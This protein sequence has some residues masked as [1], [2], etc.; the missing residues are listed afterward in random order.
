MVQSGLALNPLTLTKFVVWIIVVIS[1]TV[2]LI[3]GR[4]TK[5]TRLAFVI[6]GVILFGFIYGAVLAPG[7]NPNPVASVR[8]L[9]KGLLV[10]KKLVAPVVGMLVVMLAITVVSNKSFCGYACQLG[11][12]QDLLHR[13]PTPKWQPPFWLSNTIRIIAFLALVGGLA[14]AGLDWIGVIDPFQL[15]QFNFTLPIILASVGV[16]A[17]SLF[18]YRPWCR[19][20]CPFGLLSWVAEQVSVFRPRIDRDVCKGCQACVKACPSGAMQDFYE[21]KTLHADCFACGACIEACKVE[22]ALGWR[23]KQ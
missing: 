20:L 21:G 9:L 18:I 5:R 15:F 3:R 19:F 4:M 10:Q 1:A 22:D 2:F 17:G 8:T 16:L 12:L 23:K 7:L 6:G 13:V 11:L 14:V